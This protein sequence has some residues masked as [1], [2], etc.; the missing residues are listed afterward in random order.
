M[1][2]AVFYLDGSIGWRK[3][4]TTILKNEWIK[5]EIKYGYNQELIF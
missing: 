3:V 2:V 5:R 1:F 4:I